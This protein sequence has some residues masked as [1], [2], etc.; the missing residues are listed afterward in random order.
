MSL[1]ERFQKENKPNLNVKWGLNTEGKWCSLFNTDFSSLSNSG[2]YVIWGYDKYNTHVIIKVGQSANLDERLSSYKY[3]NKNNKV[4]D[5]LDTFGNM[6]VTWADLQKSY[7][8]G[9]E[10][11]LG[12][13]RYSPLIADAFPDSLPIVVNCPF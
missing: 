11:Y 8:D 2:V 5:Y 9:V 3:A 1:L 12:R 13:I 4:I 6:Y 10:K 7:L